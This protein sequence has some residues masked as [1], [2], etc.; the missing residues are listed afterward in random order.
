MILNYFQSKIL[1]QR[2]IIMASA[3]LTSNLWISGYRKRLEARAI[4]IYVV[5]KGDDISGSIIVRV[6]DLKGSSKVFVQS[7]DGVGNRIWLELAHAPDPDVE[8]IIKKQIDIDPDAWV[9][10]LEEA[11]GIHLLED[12]KA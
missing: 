9:L 10:E 12:A 8:K 2:V 6:L 3:R 11:N 4:P 5:K 1:G 7:Y